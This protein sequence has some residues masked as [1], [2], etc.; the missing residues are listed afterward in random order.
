MASAPAVAAA[1]KGAGIPSEAAKGLGFRAM[2]RRRRKAGDGRL[3][4]EDEGL[5]VS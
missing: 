4:R 5:E 3:G 1:P 2:V